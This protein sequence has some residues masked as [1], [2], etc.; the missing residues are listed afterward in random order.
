MPWISCPG[1]SWWFEPHVAEAGGPIAGRTSGAVAPPRGY[2]PSAEVQIT[3]N[4]G[5]ERATVKPI[6][7]GGVAWDCS[8]VN[9]SCQHGFHRS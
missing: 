3:L 6:R 7:I 1:G 2:I 8:Q 4:L 9:Q 5:V